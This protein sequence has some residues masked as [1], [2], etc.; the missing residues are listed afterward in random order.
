MNITGKSISGNCH[1]RVEIL[2]RKDGSFIVRY[3]MSHKCWDLSIE[4]THK[5]KHVAASPYKIKDPVYSEYCRC[6]QQID[7]WLK[8]YKCNATFEQIDHDLKPFERVN[9]TRVRRK[10][11]E[12]YKDHPQSISVCHYVIHSNRVFRQCFGQHVG[13]NMFSDNLLVSLARWVKL[14]DTEFFVNLGDYPLI[15]KGGIQRTHGPLPVFSWCGS[16]ESFDIVLPTYDLT[17]SSLEAMGRVTLDMMSVQNARLR[18]EDK[19]PVA[20]WRGRDSRRERLQLVD[21][22]REYPD[23]FNASITNFF[24][25]REEEVRYGPK[26]PH[27]GFFEFFDVSLMFLRIQKTTIFPLCKSHP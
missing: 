1:V 8:N 11:M 10:I 5:G 19:D 2:D 22:A 23:M 15:R 26:V 6:P 13:F 14:P 27:I 4:I 17:E 9:F 25:Y 16:E 3:K 24:F 21:I 18:W 7:Q 20:F 12:K